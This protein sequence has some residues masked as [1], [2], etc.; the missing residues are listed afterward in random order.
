[1]HPLRFLIPMGHRCWTCWNRNIQNRCC[2]YLSDRLFTPPFLFSV[3]IAYAA[4]TIVGTTVITA[5]IILTARFFADT[6][7]VARF[8]IA[9]LSFLGTELRAES[10]F[11]RIS[12][13]H[14]HFA[15]ELKNLTPT[16]Y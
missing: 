4:M 6:A 16:Q 1:M 12:S 14:F 13:C 3:M 15:E 8:A 11:F 9:L 10:A 5:L 7:R 2:P